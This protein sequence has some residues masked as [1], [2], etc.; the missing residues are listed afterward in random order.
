MWC[1]KVHVFRLIRQVL[2]AMD[3]QHRW[4]QWGL[5]RRMPNKRK[6]VIG[7]MMIAGLG[8]WLFSG[9]IRSCAATLNLRVAHEAKQAS[10]NLEAEMSPAARCALHCAASVISGA[11]AAANRTAG[12]A[13]MLC[14]RMMKASSA[15]KASS[16]AAAQDVWQDVQLASRWVNSTGVAQTSKRHIQG[17]HDSFHSACRFLSQS[18]EVARCKAIS[19]Y[20]SAAHSLA[21]TAE[22]IAESADK[23]LEFKEISF[24]Y[25]VLSNPERRRDYDEKGD[26]LFYTGPPSSPEELAEMLLRGPGGKPA[27]R[28]SKDRFLALPVSL[29]QLYSGHTHSMVVTRRVID[30]SVPGRLTA[31][32]I[33]E[34]LTIFIE[35]GSGHGESIRFASKGDEQPE[36]EVGDLI[37]VLHELEHRRFTRRGADLFMKLDISLAEALGGFRRTLQHLDGRRMLVKGDPVLEVDGPYTKAVKGQGMPLKGRPFICGNLFLEIHIHFPEKL[38]ASVMLQLDEVLPCGVNSTETRDVDAVCTF[39][40]ADPFVQC[41]QAV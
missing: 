38:D 3:S 8:V 32:Q 21:G 26:R 13:Q 6:S 23:V 10:D 27:R 31:V 41:L 17:I 35:R 29:E 40:D 2:K 14:H 7:Y 33:Q 39:A 22:M 9:M 5:L 1:D 34:E 15:A 4:C 19:C 25:E 20:A 16:V 11:D 18:A 30:A 36:C 12:A 28:K 37:V 24:A